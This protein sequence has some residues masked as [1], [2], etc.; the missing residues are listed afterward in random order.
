M[1]KETLIENIQKSV[2][3][4]KIDD[5]EENMEAACEQFQCDCC[6]EHKMFAGS[7]IYKSYRLCNEC[8]LLA[9]A[10]FALKKITNIEELLN[11]ME[12]KRF[13]T[14]YSSLFN[15]EENSMN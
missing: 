8:V 13:E 2:E 10:S 15:V 9:E 3:K 12:D 14:L 5:I 4:M 11:K 6:G 1:E 7:L